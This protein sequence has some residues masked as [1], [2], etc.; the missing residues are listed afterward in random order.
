MQRR[1]REGTG[2]VE[3]LRPSSQCVGAE[4][5]SVFILLGDCRQR[6]ADN[7]PPVLFELVSQ[8]PH[9]DFGEA[10]VVSRTRPIGLGRCRRNFLP[11]HKHALP[12]PKTGNQARPVAFF[13]SAPCYC[14][15]QA[16]LRHTVFDSDLAFSAEATRS[17]RVVCSPLRRS[18]SMT[19]SRVKVSS[20]RP[21]E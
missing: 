1:G 21:T 6:V 20:S 2:V 19:K 10:L 13:H 15:S 14:P 4:T 17:T 11:E 12:M 7:A 18:S 5:G 16:M 3:F 9:E 8:S